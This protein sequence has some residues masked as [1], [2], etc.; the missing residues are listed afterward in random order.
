MNDA[1]Y[2]ISHI[3]KNTYFMSI[4]FDLQRLNAIYNKEYLNESLKWALNEL[5]KSDDEPEQPKRP[6]GRPKKMN[7]AQ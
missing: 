5:D 7:T 3:K 6:R 1:L 2:D 4:Q